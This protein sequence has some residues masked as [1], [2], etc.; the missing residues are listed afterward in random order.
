MRRR[1]PDFDSFPRL[2]PFIQGLGLLGRDRSNWIVIGAAQRPKL[3]SPGVTKYV[4]VIIGSNRPKLRCALR[5]LNPDRTPL[6]TNKQ[7]LALAKGTNL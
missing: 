3:P 2:G 4:G 5:H 7:T 6:V 1:Y